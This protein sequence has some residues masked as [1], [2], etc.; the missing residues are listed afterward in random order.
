M[1]P[2]VC[3]ALQARS[4]VTP[5]KSQNFHLVFYG[6]FSCQCT[7]VCSLYKGCDLHKQC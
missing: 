6:V 3:V 5:K 1:F 4:S 7:N 2:H